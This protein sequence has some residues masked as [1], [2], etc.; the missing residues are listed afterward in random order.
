MKKL[1]FL[2]S[3]VL[4]CLS[5]KAQINLNDG[6]WKCVLD[7]QL[8]EEASHWK[9]DTK[10]FMNEGAYSLK[11]DLGTIAPK[12]AREIYQFNN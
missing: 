9:W 3:I 1:L 7:E 12:G 5:A 10:R 11:S 4:L 2:C 6:S 8:D